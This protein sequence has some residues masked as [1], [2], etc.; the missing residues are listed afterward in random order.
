MLEEFITSSLLFIVC[1]PTDRTMTLMFTS[2]FYATESSW[3]LK[4]V[5][6]FSQC[7]HNVSKTY[8]NRFE[9][10]YSNTDVEVLYE[11]NLGNLCTYRSYTFTFFDSA[12]DGCTSAEFGQGHWELYI[13]GTTLLGSSDCAFTDSTSLTFTVPEHPPTALPTPAPT[14]TPTVLPSHSLAPTL[15]PSQ[16]P[17]PLPT[18]PS[19]APSSVPV[20]CGTCDQTLVLDLLTDSYGEETF[21]TLVPLKS[22][23][24]CA[25]NGSYGGGPFPNDDYGTLQ[26]VTLSTQICAHEA[27][28]F[29]LLDTF[30]DGIATFT[31]PSPTGSK[32]VK[33]LSTSS[34]V[35]VVVY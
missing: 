33:H 6:P 35:V 5:G 14:W 28:L 30:G 15:T 8:P 1:A 21:W 7:S 22:A 3:T 4:P 27:Y 32:L 13:D 17:T 25:V 16:T 26:Q 10:A 23:K 20:P 19:P 34:A 2:D 11:Y 31:F 29:T 12:G 24:S 18:A 9:N